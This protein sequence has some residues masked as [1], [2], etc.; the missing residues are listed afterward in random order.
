M[1]KIYINGNALFLTDT[2]SVKG[3]KSTELRLVAPYSGKTKMLLSYIDMLEKTDRFDEIV[4][5][6][7][8]PKLILEDLESLFLVIRAAGGV[9]QDEKGKLLMIYRKKHWDLPKGKI[10]PGEKKKAAAIRET[11]EETGVK[12]L[13]ISSKLMT[14]RHS[15]KH[16]SGKRALKKTYWYCMHTHNQALIPQR[17]EDITKAE[18]MP[19]EIALD[20]K[21]PIYGN[22]LDILQR[23]NDQK[24]LSGL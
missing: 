19:M 8:N 7:K 17:E 20:I 6:H 22:I 11:E 4:L 15:F 2:K 10:D 21:E 16:K 3:Q 24:T 1:Y 12:D 14:T 23:Y 5:Y 13:F 9:V 18:W